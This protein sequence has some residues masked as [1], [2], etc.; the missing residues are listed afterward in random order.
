MNLVVRKNQK[1]AHAVVEKGPNLI[2][3]DSR[4][5]LSMYD[6]AFL[7]QKQVGLEIPRYCC[8]R[9]ATQSSSDSSSESSS[10]S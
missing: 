7:K 5:H 3:L 6:R 1:L 9:G 10:S 4:C 2:K 8:K